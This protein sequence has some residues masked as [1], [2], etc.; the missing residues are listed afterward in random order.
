MSYAIPSLS[1]GN[2]ERLSLK[3]KIQLPFAESARTCQDTNWGNRRGTTCS[4]M[5]GGGQFEDR[6][7]K[8][9]AK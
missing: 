7:H 2:W 4:S 3:V 6:L 5:G 9:A 1:L 8:Q